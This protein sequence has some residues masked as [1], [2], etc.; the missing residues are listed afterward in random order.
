MQRGRGSC[1]SARANSI[2]CVIL[3]VVELEVGIV[4]MIEKNQVCKVLHI[5]RGRYR[6]LSSHGLEWT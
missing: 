4:L 6:V 1:T 2:V 3:A 5:R